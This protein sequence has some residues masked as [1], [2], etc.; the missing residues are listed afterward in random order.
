MAF[1]VSFLFSAQLISLMTAFALEWTLFG[2]ELRTFVLLCT[3]SR[4]ASRRSGREQGGGEP[5]DEAARQGGVQAL[6]RQPAPRAPLRLSQEQRA[7]VTELLKRGA[8]RLTAF[9]RAMDV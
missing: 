7:R 2:I 6:K 3:Q 8:L 5:V 4:R 9:G 1:I